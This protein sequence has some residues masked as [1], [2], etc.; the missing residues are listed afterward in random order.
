MCKIDRLQYNI[1]LFAYPVT[2]PPKK[3]PSRIEL[4]FDVLKSPKYTKQMKELSWKGIFSK[5]LLNPH[6][7][8]K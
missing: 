1:L 3:S 6:I 7:S 2:S 8:R 4:S 5:A